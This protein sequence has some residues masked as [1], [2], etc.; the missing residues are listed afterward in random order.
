MKEYRKAVTNSSSSS[1]SWSEFA[2]T[3][4][5]QAV[6]EASAVIRE[7]IQEVE[8]T[9]DGAQEAVGGH[10]QEE[11]ARVLQTNGEIEPTR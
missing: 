5:P 4:S 7:I 8:N 6:K 11:I 2:I 1:S 3:G 9:H 10:K